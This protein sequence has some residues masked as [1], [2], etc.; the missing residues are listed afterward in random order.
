MLENV[1]DWAKKFAEPDELASVKRA[2]KYN[3]LDV[4]WP[5]IRPMRA[6]ARLQGWD[7]PWLFFR[8]AFLE[9]MLE[10]D[11]N[12]RLALA[13]TGVQIMIPRKEVT[14]PIK[15]IDELDALYESRGE[16]GRPDSWGMLVGELR[17]IRRAAEVGVKINIEGGPR[18][19][20][21]AGCYEWAHGRYSMLE[22]GYD[23]WIGDDKS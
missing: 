3:R 22:D 4:I 2:R 7:T 1:P 13:E 14:I 10:S 18:F 19:F 23:S 12:F 16:D 9:A 20:S 21:W 11:T 15:R 5:D 17:E 6:W 8:D